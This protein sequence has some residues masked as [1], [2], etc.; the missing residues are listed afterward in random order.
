MDKPNNHPLH[1]CDFLLPPTTRLVSEA[2][3]TFEHF[4][5][6]NKFYLH[7]PFVVVKRKA[8]FCRM[9]IVGATL[10]ETKVNII[11]DYNFTEGL[12]SS[13]AMFALEE[14]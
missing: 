12:F 9:Q 7:L 8:S 5:V 14:L 2:K 1:Q 3:L 4:W 11:L 10:V 6:R 13:A